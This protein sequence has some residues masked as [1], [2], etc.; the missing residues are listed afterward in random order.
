MGLDSACVTCGVIEAGYI[1]DVKSQVGDVCRSTETFYFPFMPSPSLPHIVF[2]VQEFH[3][4]TSSL[5]NPDLLTYPPAAPLY[6]PFR[7]IIRYGKYVRRYAADFAVEQVRLDNGTQ[8]KSDTMADTNVD[9]NVDANVDIKISTKVDAKVNTK[10]DTEVNTYVDILV[11]QVNRSIS[12]FEAFP[13]QTS[14]MDSASKSEK[15]KQW[16]GGLPSPSDFDI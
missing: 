11:L 4:C 2:P 3:N 10:V 15:H 14:P 8:C 7:V 1:Y 6:P 16:D 12:M 5:R 13:L 9:A